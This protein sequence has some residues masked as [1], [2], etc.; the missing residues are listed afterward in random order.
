ML[1]ALAGTLGGC[2][3]ITWESQSP[4]SLPA[5]SL[6]TIP[7]TVCRQV[8][9]SG[10]LQSDPADPHVAW[11]E[12]DNEQRIEVVWPTGYRGEWNTFGDGHWLAVYDT[13]ERLFMTTT[14]IPSARH[15]CDAG[16][17]GTVLLMQT[18]P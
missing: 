6:P 1:V 3:S 17:P 5:P 14:D 4:G 16:R 7:A 12:T 2:L 18:D 15:I 11:L 8:R 10:V 13:N 9:I